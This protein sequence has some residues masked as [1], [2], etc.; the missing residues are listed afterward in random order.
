MLTELCNK[1]LRIKLLARGLLLSIIIFVSLFNSTLEGA[2]NAVED[3]DFIS[4]DNYTNSRLEYYSYIPQAVIENKSMAYSLLVMVPGLSGRGEQFV[5]YEFK[6]FAEREGFIILAPSFMYDEQ[7][8][9]AKRSYQ[10]PEAWSGNALLEIIDKL[11]AKNDLKIAKCYL[12]G[13]SA[14]AQFALRFC[15]WRPDLCAACA[16]HAGGGTIQPN[17]K[18]Y[19]NFFITAGTQDTDRLEKAQ[20]FYNA[21]LACGIDVTFKEY[22]TGH[23][24]T[25]AQIQDS[26]EF[27]KKK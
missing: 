14:G 22:P 11:K 16:A 9:S 7:N 26:L 12:F 19:V 15:F 21:A 18:I 24:L 23:S 8:W 25:P 13:F 17:R 5:T 3:R 4:T 20:G 2:G 27:F 1:M 10:F 6:E